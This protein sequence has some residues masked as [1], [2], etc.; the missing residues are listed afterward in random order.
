MDDSSGVDDECELLQN[1]ISAPPLN[2]D[3]GHAGPPRR[4][5]AFLTKGRRYAEAGILRHRAAP[6]CF[7]CCT[8]DDR[9]LAQCAADRV[10]RRARIPAGA[11]KQAEAEPD[12]IDTRR[13]SRF[14]HEA[15]DRPIGPAGAD[16]AQITRAE[17]VV[18]EIVR[19]SA[20]PLRSHI[21]PMIGPPDREL[22]EGYIV[23]P[24]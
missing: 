8:L 18:R 15:F 6:A 3:A 24:L 19:E 22:V 23:Y 5:R 1:Y 7:L 14:V 9:G 16:R 4:H 20:N 21:V 11:V 10:R 13:V 2:A 12:R 17:G